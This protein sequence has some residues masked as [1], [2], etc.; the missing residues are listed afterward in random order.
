MKLVD[1]TEFR[2]KEQKKAVRRTPQLRM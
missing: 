2:K 1:F